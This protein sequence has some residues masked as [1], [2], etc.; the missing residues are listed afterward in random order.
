MNSDGSFDTRRPSLQHK[1][2]GKGGDA[3]SWFRKFKN[4]MLG[5]QTRADTGF[6]IEAEASFESE[7][8]RNRLWYRGQAGELQQYYELYDDRVGNTSF[9][10]ARGARG[11]TFRK[12]HCGLPALMVNALSDIVC[13]DMLSIR[14]EGGGGQAD[15][16]AIAQANG[17]DRLL[18]RAVRTALAEGDGAFKLSV[19]AAAD[20]MP[21]L[22]FHGGSGVGMVYKRQRLEGICFD[23]EFTENGES[24]RLRELYGKDGVT[25]RLTDRK[26]KEL[27]L[28]ATGVT[29]GLADLANPHGFLPAAALMFDENPR[30]EGRGRSVY[31]S[32]TGVF[33]ALDECVSQWVDA[34]RD[35]RVQTYIPDG[36]LPRDPETG[37][38]LRPNAFNARYVVKEDPALEGLT[39]HIEVVQPSIS[40]GALLESYTTFLDLCLQGILSPSTLGVDVKKLDNAEAQREKEKATLYTRG[41][42]I[43]VLR[44]TIPEVVRAALRTYDWMRGREPGDYGVTV[45]FGEYA[46]PS[47]E[48][49]VETVAKAYA[50]GIM[51]VET[52][53]NELYG[54]S[55]T[56]EQKDAEAARL[57]GVSP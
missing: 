9:W 31:D 15:W 3:L 25:Y 52:A 48:A 6:V 29:N 41:R 39:P 24:Y 13:T 36:Y 2:M 26:N 1:F 46:N 30:F 22:S 20:A 40:T 56:A 18:R 8:F 28:S 42:L 54:S 17:F 12:L 11:L 43:A 44:E 37:A 49:Q 5:G 23:S 19:D 14:V 10:G 45:E 47:F 21:F 57:R 27:P 32:K 55:W 33:D 34:L 51:S 50:G 16:D 4:G 7:A 53:V 38:L 35:G